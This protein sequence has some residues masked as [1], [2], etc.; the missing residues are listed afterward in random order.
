MNMYLGN[1]HFE[2]I[3]CNMDTSLPQGNTS[4]GGGCYLPMLLGESHVVNPVS[5]P[6]GVGPTLG[7]VAGL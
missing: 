5:V 7:L 6:I 2:V 4:P 1:N 3:L